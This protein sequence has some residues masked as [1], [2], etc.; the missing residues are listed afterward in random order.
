L[1]CHKSVISVDQIYF[2]TFCYSPKSNKK[3]AAT[4]KE[5]KNQFALAFQRKDFFC[6]FLSPQKGTKPAGLAWAHWWQA[7][8]TYGLNSLRL[9]PRLRSDSSPNTHCIDSAL[10][11]CQRLFYLEKITAYMAVYITSTY[12]NY[13]FN[14]W[15]FCN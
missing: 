2:L 3:A 8:K 9:V 4:E 6:S 14:S 12:Y 10:N 5:P 15:H 1:F 11:N 13:L 7:G